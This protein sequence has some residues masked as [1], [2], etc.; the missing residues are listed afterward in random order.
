MKIACLTHLSAAFVRYLMWLPTL[1]GEKKIEEICRWGGR[2]S[3]FWRRTPR[4]RLLP[5]DAPL[6]CS[7]SSSTEISTRTDRPT[8]RQPTLTHSGKPLIQLQV[9]RNSFL[10]KTQ[11]VDLFVISLNIFYSS[12]FTI[13]ISASDKFLL[14]LSSSFRSL[15]SASQF[16]SPLSILTALLSFPFFNLFGYS[17]SLSVNVTKK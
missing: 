14:F 3:C 11:K 2:R 15:F 6:P 9:S 13:S 5:R 16:I 8:P 17:D 1:N 12:N 7:S 4:P 10:M